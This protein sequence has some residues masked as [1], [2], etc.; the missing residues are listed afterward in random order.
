MLRGQKRSVF[1]IICIWLGGWKSVGVGEKKQFISNNYYYAHFKKKELCRKAK[2]KEV[3]FLTS[4]PSHPNFLSCFLS[5]LKRKNSV[6]PGGKLLDPTSFLFPLLFQPNNIFFLLSF[7]SNP[8]F[9]SNLFSTQPNDT[10]V[11][12]CCCKFYNIEWTCITDFKTNSFNT[13][14]EVLDKLINN[15][16]GLT[17]N[18]KLQCQHMFLRLVE[19]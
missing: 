6:G 10:L 15:S 3:F 14:F 12:S 8:Y 1:S 13:F 17:F 11:S 7:L 5:D 16:I 18:K 19:S 9:L 2:G 4:M